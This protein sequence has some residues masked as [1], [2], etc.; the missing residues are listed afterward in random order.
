VPQAFK[1]FTPECASN[2]LQQCERQQVVNAYDNTIAYTDHFLAETIGWLKKQKGAGAMV[3]V[4]DHGE[5][6]GEN[7]L[8]LHGLPYAIAPDVQKRVPWITWTSPAFDQQRGL[9]KSCLQDKKTSPI[10]HDHY[11]HSVLGIA[12][13]RSVEYRPEWPYRAKKRCCD[14]G[15]SCGGDRLDR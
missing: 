12:G 5:S 13:V 1:R 7:N 2:A 4:A 9:R 3:Y 11:F 14:N 15:K 10:S 6:L 8:Y